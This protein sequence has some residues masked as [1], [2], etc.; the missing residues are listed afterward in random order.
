MEK[1]TPAISVLP[2]PPPRGMKNLA[3]T[4]SLWPR[5]TTGCAALPM[6]Q[7]PQ[8]RSYKATPCIRFRT[9]RGYPNAISSNL[10]HLNLGDDPVS[11][12]SV[13]DK[14]VS[15]YYFFRDDILSLIIRMAKKN[16]FQL[17]VDW[18]NISIKLRMFAHLLI[19]PCFVYSYFQT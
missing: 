7:P 8:F 5:N 16:V 12:S 2:K 1:A 10:S 15:T 11:G 17:E 3:F 9:T 4:S 6:Q 18:K 14:T 13:L 19:A